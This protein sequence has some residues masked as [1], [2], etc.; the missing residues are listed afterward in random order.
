M[1]YGSSSV[2]VPVNGERAKPQADANGR[3]KEMPDFGTM[4]QAE[5]L[6]W[7]K[8]KRDRIFGSY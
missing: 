3:A 2:S 5:K 1:S 6:A 4:N 8:A 7:Q